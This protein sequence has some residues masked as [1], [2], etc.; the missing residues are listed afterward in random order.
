MIE[1]KYINH[2]GD[3]LTVVNAA[4]VSFNKV[5][6]LECIDMQK[7]KYAMKHDDKKLIK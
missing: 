6:Q 3:D 1:V 7:G 4:R 2:M 5:S